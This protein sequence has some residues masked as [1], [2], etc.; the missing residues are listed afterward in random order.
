MLELL[1][2][3]LLDASLFDILS[4][5]LPGMSRRLTVLSQRGVSLL[6]LLETPHPSYAKV[7]D[8][9]LEEAADL[10]DTGSGL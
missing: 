2:S 8:D 10:L 7:I 9:C 5:G 1:G 6:S 3:F 4:D